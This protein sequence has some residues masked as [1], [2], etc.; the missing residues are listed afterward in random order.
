MK[1]YLRPCAAVSSEI[2]IKHSRFICYI[3]PVSGREAAEAFIESIRQQHPKA[4]HNCWSYVAGYPEDPQQWNCSDDGEP[5]G[6]AGQ[7][8]LNILRHSGIGEICA[9]V[10]RYFGGVKLGTGGLVR[11]YGQS[12]NESIRLLE[13]EPVVPQLDISLS[14]GYELTGD[15]EQ[16]ISRF[17]ILVKERL[18][19]QQLLIH[20]SIETQLL[21]DLKL[22]LQPIQHKVSLSYDNKAV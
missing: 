22:A 11:A 19:E 12:L 2:I 9:V 4:N 20:G 7:P 5:K 10:T 3:A 6:T 1:T 13:T 8:M 16:L 14:A 21:E 15:L 17:N 18:F